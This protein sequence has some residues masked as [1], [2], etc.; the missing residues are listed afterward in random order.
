MHC[1]IRSL[2]SPGIIAALY[3]PHK[4][5][6]FS[7]SAGDNY[8]NEDWIFSEHSDFGHIKYILSSIE[9]VLQ[10]DIFYEVRI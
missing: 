3:K 7:M 4:L 10:Q 9:T 8:E 6:S 1:S 2:I 5:C